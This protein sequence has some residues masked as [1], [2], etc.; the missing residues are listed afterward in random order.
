M[1]DNVILIDNG[2][3]VLQMKHEQ[4][5]DALNGKVW[6]ITTAERILNLN[7]GKIISKRKNSNSFTYK[8]V[9]EYPPENATSITPSLEDAYMFYV[10]VSE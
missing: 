8:I 2:N 6:E 4:I 7:N 5:M 1:C 9:T 10:G 3:I